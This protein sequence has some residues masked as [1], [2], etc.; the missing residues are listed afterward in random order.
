LIFAVEGDGVILPDLFILGRI[1]N[2]EDQHYLFA[3]L[4]LAIVRRVL[5]ID[6]QAEAR[7]IPN[8]EVENPVYDILVQVVDLRLLQ[9]ELA[10]DDDG[11]HLP[12]GQRKGR[13]H[14]LDIVREGFC[15]HF[16]EEG[17]LFDEHSDIGHVFEF[18]EDRPVVV[19][20]DFAQASG[21][22]LIEKEQIILPAEIRADRGIALGI[23]E[24][25]LDK[26]SDELDV[27][28]DGSLEL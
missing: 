8:H 26:F 24:I 6:L 23:E 11:E 13:I 10:V 9:D 1:G 2:R 16:P 14:F 15:Q 4:P 28:M 12:H 21:R 3:V 7:K 19:E 20:L 18:S 17:D 25:V 5:P 27:H 22:A